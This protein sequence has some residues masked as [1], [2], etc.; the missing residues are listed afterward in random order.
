MKWVTGER[1]TVDRLACSW[2]I[3]HFV[4]PDAEFL[5]G[6]AAQVLTVTATQQAIPLDAPGTPLGHHGQRCT[7]EAILNHY[8]LDDPALAHLGQIVYGADTDNSLGGQPESEGLHA[9]AE[10][11]GLLG[12]TDNPALLTAQWIVYDALYAYCYEQAR[13]RGLSQSILFLCPHNAAKSVLAAAY[14]RQVAREGGLELD[15]VS[16]GTAPGATVAPAV[17]ALLQREGLGVGPYR[18][19]L[20]TVEDLT[21]ARHVVSLGCRLDELPI[22]PATYEMWDDIPAPSQN[23]A[24]AQQTIRERVLQLVEAWS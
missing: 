2:L 11:M 5:F 1:A 12:V 22:Q 7:F 17:A 21:H 18:P 3:R 14:F 19:R 4:D 9:I 16:A 6:P 15:A 13:R 8:G 23:L 20:V 10:G 24:G